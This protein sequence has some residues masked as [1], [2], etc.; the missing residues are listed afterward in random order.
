MI[1][2][3][4]TSRNLGSSA[5]TAVLSLR[6]WE[7][8]TPVF[9]PVGTKA[10]VKAMTPEEMKQIGARIIL[11]NTFH[12]FL[13]PGDEV[14]R[15]LGGLHKFM[16]WDGPILTDSGGFQ[17]FSLSKLNKITEEGVQFR[18]PL[19]GSAHFLSPERATQIQQN[20]GADI[21]MAFDEC[22]PYPASYE[23]A[24]D[25]AEMTARWAKRCKQALQRTDQALFGIVQGGTYDELR[26]WSARAT[27][28]IGFPGYAIGG[29]SV[30]EPKEKMLA[31]L[32]V[33]D[34]ILP[35]DQ[36]RYLM[37]VGTPED[38]FTGIENGVDMFD[39]VLPTRTA[40]NGRLYTN[41]GIINIRNSRYA[42]DAEPLSATCN[43][44]C[45]SNYSRAYL[46][47]LFMANEIL[48]HRLATWH[49]LYYFCD[50]MARI[51]RAIRHGVLGAFKRE[52]MA[53]YKASEETDEGAQAPAP[54]E[55]ETLK[56]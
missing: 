42:T 30:G 26:E 36:P 24:K 4:V 1:K 16:N 35:A 28:D 14:V 33:V 47:H 52:V 56:A 55:D 13:R 10:T 18:S 17:V 48:G 20:L 8:E 49:N 29:L 22:V 53:V 46:R 50:L 3:N 6:G 43:C 45:C 41:E 21:I 37:G 31:S 19:D 5:R 9:M 25:S 51:R 32:Q 54:S 34:A 39:C 23:Y 27:V 44:Y 2:F 7:V 38:F 12:L 40:R 11:A 15:D